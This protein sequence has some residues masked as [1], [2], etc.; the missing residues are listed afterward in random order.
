M[1]INFNSRD[2]VYVQVVRHF[3]RQIAMAFSGARRA[4]PV[5]A[6]TGQYAQN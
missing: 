3:K 5:Q 4:N 6:G 2:P 1:Q